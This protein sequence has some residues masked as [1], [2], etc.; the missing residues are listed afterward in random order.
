[1]RRF[2]L[3]CNAR[4]IHNVGHHFGRTAS[5]GMGLF[6]LAVAT[7]GVPAAAFGVPPDFVSP[8]P[9]QPE[10]P[11]TTTGTGSG[12]TTANAAGPVFDSSG[13]SLL[14]LVTYADFGGGSP[15]ADIWGYVSPA[16]REYAIM[17]LVTTVAFVEVTDPVNPQIIAQ[18]A[19]PTSTWRDIKTHGEYCYVVIDG[20]GLGMQIID[21]SLID[22]GIVTLASTSLLGGSFFS[23]HNIAYNPDSGYAYLSGADINGGATALD[24]TDPLNPQI[25]GMWTGNYLHDVQ[26]ITYTTGPYAGQEIL[27]GFGAGSGVFIVDFTDKLNPTT[28]DSATYPGLSYC[29]Q[30]WVSQD[31]QYLFVSDELDEFGGDVPTTTTY[32]FDIQDLTNVQHVA[33]FTSGTPATDHNLFV[34]GNF[35]FEANYHSGLRIFDVSDPLNAQQAGY[36]DT[37]PENDSVGFNGMWGVYPFLPSGNVICSDRTRGLF[38]L[39]VSAVTGGAGIPTVS[40]WGTVS[41]TLLLLTAGTVMF[42]VRRRALRAA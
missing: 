34:L 6:A 3:R 36:F 17:G 2:E 5:L 33:S 20:S 1:M 35:L 32:V 21:M 29:H 23:A 22:S 19:G 39:D 8:S 18:I 16:G 13:I 38:I 30:G 31:R 37:Y 28:L 26:V 14:G 4:L 11:A 41:L 9:Q 40:Q 25:A 42:G 15:G 10:T 27:F 7:V 24:L 12:A